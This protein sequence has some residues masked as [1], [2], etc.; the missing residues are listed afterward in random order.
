[1][2]D[3]VI[4]VDE[5]DHQTGTAEKMEAHQK[6]LL[7]RAFS[8]FIIEYIHDEWYILLQRREKN[9]YHCA[10]LWTNTCCSHP[11]PNEHVQDAA[12]RRLKEEMGITAQLSEIGVFEYRAQFSNGLIEHEIDH[13]FV[14]TTDQEH[15]EINPQEVDEFRWENISSIET[16]WKA[17]ASQFTPW[18]KQA[19]DLLKVKLQ[20][21]TTW[22]P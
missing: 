18:F 8:V 6:G 5:N 17:D 11:C 15:F 9:K 20:G 14:G 13:V 16:E 7:H 12:V 10:G 4:L 2:T 1:M 21:K 22:K 3:E 19:L